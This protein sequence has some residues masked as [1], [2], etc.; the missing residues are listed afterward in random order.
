MDFDGLDQVDWAALN[1]AHGAADDVPDMLQRLCAADPQVRGEACSDLF[2]TIW[3][4]GTIFPASAEVL[5]FLFQIVANRNQ[6]RADEVDGEYI[7]PSDE[8]AVALICSIATGETWLRHAVGI[9]GVKMVQARLEQQGRSLSDEQKREKQTLELIADTFSKSSSLL[10][11]YRF[12]P[13]GLGD[14]VAE[15]LNKK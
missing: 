8:M 10:E 4:Q 9:D 12:T 15:A 1:H 6:F 11:S 7:P 14:I 5:L 13:E 2:V 3:H